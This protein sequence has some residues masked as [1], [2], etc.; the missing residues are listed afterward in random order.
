ML[1]PNPDWFIGVTAFNLMPNGV[2]IDK[3]TVSLFV[4]DAGSDNAASYTSPDSNTNPN[5]NIS[6]IK[7]SP[8][9]VGGSTEAVG[10]L[11]IEKL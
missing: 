2:W 3:A 7:V 5:E 9:Q 6:R 4:Y 8:F 1:A 10:E 11:I